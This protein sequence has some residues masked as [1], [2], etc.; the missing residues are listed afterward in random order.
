LRQFLLTN[1]SAGRALISATLGAALLVCATLVA[2][3]KL[4]RPALWSLA[5]LFTIFCFGYVN[6]TRL[7]LSPLA[8]WFGYFAGRLVRC[9]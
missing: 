2:Q 3:G 1:W 9:K 8:F 6:E 5:V 7:Y 4:V